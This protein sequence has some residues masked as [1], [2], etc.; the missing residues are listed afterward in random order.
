MVDTEQMTVVRLGPDDALAGHALSTEAHWNQNE[1]DWRFFLTRGTVFGVRDRDGHL[2]ASAALLTHSSDNAWISM[3]LVTESWRRR[4]LAT[5]LVDACLGAAAK[6]ELT[7]WL[8]ATPAGATVYGPLGFKPT[9][10]LRRLR[11]ER[12]MSTKAEAPLP[13]SSISI[14]RLTARDHFAMGFDRVSLLTELSG[15]PGS[16]LL[17]YG[18]ALALVRDGRKARHI[19]P[20]LANAPEQALALV[21]EIVLSENGPLLIDAVYEQEEFLKSLT[22]FGWNIERPFQRM[23]FGRAATP[24]AELPFAVA[25][26]EYG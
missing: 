19:G 26:P 23:R 21:N 16:R 8:D 4:G 17:S 6:Q 13:P 14:E 10:Q 9:L 25:G 18:D 1:A 24:A 5:R 3:V 2:V 12:A 7:T 11:L 15:R 22:G 20:L